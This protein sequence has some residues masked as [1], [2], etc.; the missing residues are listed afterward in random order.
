LQGE[1][2]ARDVP[3]GR[4]SATGGRGLRPPHAALGLQWALEQGCLDAQAREVFALRQRVQDALVELAQGVPK[5]AAIESIALLAYSGG[6]TR[7]QPEWVQTIARAQQQEGGW[8]E[9][10]NALPNDHTTTL[11]LWVLLEATRQGNTVA[12]VPQ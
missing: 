5:D 2:L 9:T 3:E 7:V 4:G 12:W 11:A 8:G 1:R 6:W 10:E